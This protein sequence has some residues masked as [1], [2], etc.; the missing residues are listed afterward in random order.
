MLQ[1]TTVIPDFQ[2]NGT[3]PAGIHEASW[4][5]VS[6]R[7]GNNPH[8]RNLL[9]GLYRALRNLKGAGCPR[10][11]LNGSFVTDKESPGDFDAAWEPVED[12]SLLDWRLTK[13]EGFANERHAQKAFY[14]GELFPANALADD[15]GTTFKEFFQRDEDGSAKGIVAI[16]MRGLP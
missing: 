3:L 12:E 5:E 8:R 15:Q 13:P 10:V 6:Q 16:D 14:G 4:H 9:D 1:P 11:Y 2:P 7:F